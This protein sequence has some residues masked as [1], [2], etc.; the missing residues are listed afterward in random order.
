M[1]QNISFY[2][3]I[4]KLKIKEVF[5]YRVAFANNLFAQFFAYMVTWINISILLKS[6]NLLNGWNI[7]EIILLWA[8]NV[9]SYGFAGMFFYNGCN[10]LEQAVQNGTIDIYYTQPKSIFWHFM[11]KNVN[12][13][14]IFHMFF[15]TILLIYSLLSLNIN[16][17]TARG[18]YFCILLFCSVC[19]QS[20][21]MIIFASS[22]FKIIK[23]GNIVSTAI[24]GFRNFTT[25]PFSIYGKG[26]R[27]MLTFLIPYAFVS[28]Y[29][30]LFILNKAHTIF[31][32]LM[33]YAEPLIV[34]VLIL[35]TFL[36][37]RK[38]TYVY[39]GTGT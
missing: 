15:S 26:I 3:Y 20:C 6:I 29:P 24:Y 9:F 28:Y 18:I 36:L 5:Q 14:F 34:I 12:P 17:S 38:G 16:F 39:K 27:F 8:L 31:D 25:Y 35:I 4:I 19:V 1:R 21:I 33:I 2:L 32:M 23:S 11:F 22:S 7:K 10:G 37:W 30:G 13:I